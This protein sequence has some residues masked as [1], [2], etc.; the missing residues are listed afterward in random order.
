M[1]ITSGRDLKDEVKKALWGKWETVYGP[2]LR[3]RTKVVSGKGG[4]RELETNCPFPGHPDKNPSFQFDPVA[5]NGLAGQSVA[6]DPAS[7]SS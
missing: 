3:G 1:A 2:Y 6:L 4:R 5:E 7:T